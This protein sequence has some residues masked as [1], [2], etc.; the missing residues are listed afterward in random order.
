MERERGEGGLPQRKE[1][2]VVCCNLRLDGLNS[3]CLGSDHSRRFLFPMAPVSYQ[4]PFFLLVI[5]PTAKNSSVHSVCELRRSL[6]VYIWGRLSTLVFFIR[7]Y[8]T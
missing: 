8:I 7:E 4:F 3:M 5:W 1:E 6:S 2:F